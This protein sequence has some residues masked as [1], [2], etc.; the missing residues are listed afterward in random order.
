[1]NNGQSFTKKKYFCID[2][3]NNISDNTN[4]GGN[5]PNTDNHSESIYSTIIIKQES[6]HIS[7]PNAKVI[8]K[9][10]KHFNKPILSHLQKKSSKNISRIVNLK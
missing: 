7:S 6:G 2:N 8:A 9:P 5:V 3:L 4:I 10:I 1:M